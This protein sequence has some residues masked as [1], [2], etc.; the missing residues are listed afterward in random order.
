MRKHFHAKSGE[1]SPDHLL[2]NID[3]LMNAALATSTK[4]TYKRA[5]DQFNVFS[6]AIFGKVMIPHLTVSTI[7]LFISYLFHNKFAPTTISTYLS[8]IGYV[9]T[10]LHFVDPTQSF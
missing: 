2:G 5:W 1:V 9:H 4:I 8:V 3:K 10:M 7:S 6:L